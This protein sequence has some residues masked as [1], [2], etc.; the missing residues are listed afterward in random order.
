MIKYCIKCLFPETKPDL[1]FNKEGIC[2]A[3]TNYLNRPKID[4]D[5]REKEF[6]K[7]YRLKQLLLGSELFRTV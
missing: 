1:E 5:K 7:L 3:C 4:W 2:N 6:L